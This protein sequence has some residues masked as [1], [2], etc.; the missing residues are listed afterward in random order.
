MQI[1]RMVSC[2][3]YG[4]YTVFNGVDAEKKNEL[5]LDE[6]ELAVTKINTKE[7]LQERIQ[8]SM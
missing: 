5:C 7:K 4:V 1:L 8:I 6:V 3:D 2:S